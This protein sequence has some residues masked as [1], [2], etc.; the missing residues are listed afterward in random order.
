VNLRDSVILITGASSGFGAATARRCAAAGARLALSARSAAALEE[1][2]ARSAA[3][4]ARP[5]PC[6]PT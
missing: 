3:P 6:P 2:A 1:L 4:V 5:W